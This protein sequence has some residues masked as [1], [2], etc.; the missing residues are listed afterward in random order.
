VC[1]RCSLL[2]LLL[3]VHGDP[4]LILPP[5]DAK[6]CSVSAGAAA[7]SVVAGLPGGRVPAAYLLLLAGVLAHDKMVAANAPFIGVDMDTTHVDPS[8][9]QSF[10]T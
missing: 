9:L 10:N 4:Q 8:T 5:C 3:H 6:A 2:L 7:V 1:C